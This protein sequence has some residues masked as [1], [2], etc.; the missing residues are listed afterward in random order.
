L[1]IYVASFLICTSHY[2]FS[3]L[4]ISEIIHDVNEEGNDVRDDIDSLDDDHD[5]DLILTTC[6]PMNSYVMPA[7][8]MQSPIGGHGVNN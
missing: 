5:T 8:L 3:A 6:E 2:F 1:S 4:H 7:T